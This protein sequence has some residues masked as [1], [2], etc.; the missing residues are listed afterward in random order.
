MLAN[1]R[2][3]RSLSDIGFGRIRTQL[4]YKAVRYG[5]QV[6][7]ADRWYPSSKLC[8]GC[9]FKHATLALNE[10]AWTCSQCGAQHKRDHNAAINLARLAAGAADICSGNALPVASQ[11]AT[12]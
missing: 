8:S 10:R 4:E 12:V 2:L 3:A 1:G 7:V 9:G 6:L 5:T 11:A